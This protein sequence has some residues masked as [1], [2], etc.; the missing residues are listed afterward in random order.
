[1]NVAGPLIH[2]FTFNDGTAHDSIGGMKGTLKG[3]ATVVNG[4]LSLDG[5]DGGF[6]LLSDY[7]MPPSGSATVVAWF[8]T[9]ST[10][11]KS[12][13]VFDFGSGTLNYLYFTP[14]TDVGGTARL[15]IKTGD[16]A[17]TYVTT[18]PILNDDQ[19]HMMAAVIDS[20]PGTGANG[21]MSLYIDGTLA[22]A[23]DLN[24]T[25]SLSG[26][27]SGPQNFLG[28]SQWVNTGD[29]PYKGFMDEVRVYST[30]LTQEAIAALV[31]DTNPP[32]AP[33]I[34]TQPQDTV[35]DVGGSA[36]LRVGVT[37]SKPLTFQWRF[38]GNN[39][40]AAN[41]N[42]FTLTNVQSSD[43]GSYDVVV[44]NSV[45]SVTSLVARV[46]LNRWSYARWDDDA[47]SGVDSQYLYTHAFNFGAATDTLINGLIFKGAPDG[48]PSVANAFT[49]TGVGS[50]YNNDFNNLPDGSGSRTLAN[51][52]I[53]GGNPGTLALEGLTPGRQYLLTLYSVGW[54]DAG[55]TIRFAAADG[56]Q[57]TLDQDTYQNDNGIRISY[58]YTADAA[59]S[60]SV[61]VSQVGI[62]THHMYGFSNRELQLPGTEVNLQIARGAA[63]AVVISWPQSATGFTL[64][65]TAALGA[66]ANWQT[67]NATPVVSE[68]FYRV[69]VPASSGTQFF[70]LQK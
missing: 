51:D 34:D 40:P 3:T 57:F 60:F 36:S 23:S 70:Q 14:M 42:V 58:Q 67:V 41:T 66:A 49:V 7:A 35:A 47:T 9:F 64:K 46:S 44:A 33:V 50:V 4:Q 8:R 16:D 65:A 25:I 13:R 38:N 27:D 31:P 22:G 26:L 29:L 30:A 2:Q 17:E 21:T 39:L 37:G 55:R 32:A 15:G 54:E 63:G 19:D 20:T 45:G 59:G 69:T 11:G 6:V 68:G 12:S 43:F 18:T 62:G 24:G 53:Y 52:F 28:K 1:L 61:T 48:N 56:Q 5:S 10:V